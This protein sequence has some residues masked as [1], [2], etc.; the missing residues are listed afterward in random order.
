MR[1]PF[2][3]RPGHLDSER[4]GVWPALGRYGE[5]CPA[6]PG[7]SGKC[8]RR[9]TS[10]AS[11]GGRPVSRLPSRK[12]YDQRM[13]WLHDN[14][15]NLV[16]SAAIL[17]GLIFSGLA[18][19]QNAAAMK[20][21]TQL[22]VVTNH[23]ELWQNVVD[24]PALARIFEISPDPDLPTH[25]EKWFLT[26]VINHANVAFLAL[27]KNADDRQRQALQDDYRFIFGTPLARKVWAEVRNFQDPGFRDLVD[28]AL[29]RTDP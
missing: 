9:V 23:R 4:F 24:K 16:Q 28:G 2:V 22:A 5:R 21:S 20:V 12:L 17:A 19:R 15:F 7:R 1:S 13:S 26:L 8:F 6:G 10:R 27:S 18:L 14:W 25:D 3:E 29:R 11:P